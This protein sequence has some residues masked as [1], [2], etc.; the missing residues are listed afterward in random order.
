DTGWEL[1][2]VGAA[3]AELM[4]RL[5]YR[6]FGAQGGDWGAG[7]SRELGRAFPDRVIGVH[8]NLLPGAHASAEPTPE[9]LAA[10]SPRER[11][12]TLASWRRNEE[13]TRERLGYAAV[14]MT[15]PQTLSY[16]LTDSPVGQLAWIVEKFKEWTDSRERPEDAVDRDQLLTN[17][18]LYWLT[19]T[20]GS[21]ARIYYERAHADGWGAPVQPSTAPTGLAVFPRDNFIPL[22]HV[23]DRTENIVRWTEFDRGGHFAAMEEPELLIGDVRAFFRGLRQDRS[24]GGERS[25]R[26]GGAA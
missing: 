4:D 1:R 20:A 9:E 12:N 22:R 21:S 3:F 23:A 11:E 17:V 19:G 14:Q 18:M 7:I 13:W 6:R 8:L 26:V 10:L 25:V 15:R 24:D 16:G 5:G 2:R